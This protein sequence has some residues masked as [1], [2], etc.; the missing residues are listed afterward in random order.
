[1]SPESPASTAKV[2]RADCGLGVLDDVLQAF[3]R[4]PVQRELDV[5]GQAGLQKVD[6]DADLGD[7]PRQ[8]GQ[9]AR[10]PEVVE[11]GRPQP[12]DRRASLLQRQVD[13]FAGLLQLLCGGGGIVGHGPAGR[14]E[15]V[16]Q[17]D[18]PLR[19]AVVNVAGQPSPLDLLRLDDLLDEILVC[20]FAGHQLPVQSGLMQRTRDQ[21]ADHQEQ[22]HV[23]F[24]E[25]AS[26]DGVDVEDADKPA[27]AGFHRHRHHRGEV[28]TPQ[29]L[30]R[31]VARVGLLVLGDD[32]RLAV[33]GD[34]SGNALAQRQPDF[35]HLGVERRRRARERQRPVAVVEDVH[36]AHVA[37][38]GRGDHPRRRGGQRLDPGP[39]GRGLD[40]FA[41][42][43]EFAV[44]VDEVADRV[45]GTGAGAHW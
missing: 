5:V 29:R 21:P 1:M 10:Q 3:L 33:A 22:F 7:G 20:P 4:D 26:F 6:V 24:G 28:R 32:D 45:R 30:E 44:G 38:G 18:Q 8:A 2:S 11:H 17:R 27:R 34:P 35:S 25:F 43:R 13:Q 12:A 16:R 42:Q 31:H 23:A 41:Q 36:E 9:P 39:L 14:V 40:Q 37:G 15:A 19:D